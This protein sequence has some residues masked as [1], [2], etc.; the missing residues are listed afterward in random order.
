[1]KTSLWRIHLSHQENAAPPA[2][3]TN[4][5]IALLR[6]LLVPSP[7]IAG[8]SSALTGSADE[9]YGRA[10]ATSPAIPTPKIS[11]KALKTECGGFRTREETYLSD[12]RT[13]YT[14]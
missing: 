6:K 13:S 7:G 4:K 2:T 14:S 11:K 9:S 12:I 10:N 5:G 8:I 1:M 3:S